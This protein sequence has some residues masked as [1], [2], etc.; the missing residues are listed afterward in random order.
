MSL[1]EICLL[2]DYKLDINFLLRP[3]KWLFSLS[4]SLSLSHS[5]LLSSLKTRYWFRVR[6]LII[7][8][9]FET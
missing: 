4:L 5:L 2:F 9:Y 8:L 6:P 7:S 1:N 3:Q